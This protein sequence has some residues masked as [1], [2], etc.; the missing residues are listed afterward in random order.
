MTPEHQKKKGGARLAPGANAPRSKSRPKQKKRTP[1][2]RTLRALLIAGVVAAALIVL[3]GGAYL[4]LV[5]PPALSEPIQ[6][7][8]PKPGIGEPSQSEVPGGDRVVSD[9]KENF[10]TFL[11]VGQDTYGGG[12]TDTMMLASYDVPNQQLNVMSLPRDTLV[13]VS[14]DIKKLNSVYNMN[15][16]E[17]GGMEALKEEIGQLVGFR[18]DFTVTV[19]WEAVGELVDAVGGVY[20]DVPKRMYYNDLSQNFKIDLQKGYQ[21]LDG[22][23]AM[24]LLRYRLDSDDNGNAFGGYPDGDLGR[25]KTQ[26]AFLKATISQC[27]EKIGDADTVVKLAKVFLQNVTTDLNIGEVVWLGQA[28]VLGINVK[29]S[30]RLSDENV[31][32]ITM[33]WVNAN[34]VWSRTYNNQPSY[35]APDVDK[36]METINAH[37]NPYNSDLSKSELDIM[38]VNKDGTLGTT[39][40]VLQDTKYNQWVLNRPA[41]TPSPSP[42]VE[43]EPTSEPEAPTETPTQSPSPSDSPEPSPTPGASPSA[44]PSPSPSPGTSAEPTPSASP[45]PEPTQAPEPSPEPLPTGGGS[46]PPAGIPID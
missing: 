22:K 17:K 43:P 3:L 38:Y 1:R 40:G 37:F 16:G 12:N 32:F 19:Q 46:E 29:D 15:G 20:F 39:G 30:V 24:Q 36:M 13:N 45:S 42:S 18:P 7:P 8:N 11:L 6:R 4:L 35:V 25:I 10:F 34:G 21:K 44:S 26:Q 28:A 9:R 33:P 31:S 14:W 23:K 5:K 2:E 41:A 27:L